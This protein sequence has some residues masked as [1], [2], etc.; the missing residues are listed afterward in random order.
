MVIVGNKKPQRP[1]ESARRTVVRVPHAGHA[2]S[3]QPGAMEQALAAYVARASGSPTLRV[4]VS[5]Q[6]PGM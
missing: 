1:A 3:T 2:A 6:V 5:D 4:A